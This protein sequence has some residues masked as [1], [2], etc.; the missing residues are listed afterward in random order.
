MDLRPLRFTEKGFE[1]R[2]VAIRYGYDKMERFL[3]ESHDM[4]NRPDIVIRNYRPGDLD[5]LALLVSRALDAGGGLHSVSA[6]DVIEGLGRPRHSP[7]E[8]LFVAERAGG[9]IGYVDVT[10][11]LDIGRAVLSFLAHPEHRGEVVVMKLIKRAMI[12]ARELK[13]RRAHVNVPEGSESA[14]KRLANMGFRF[15]RRFLELRLDL[16]NGDVPN[17]DRISPR[18]R[19]LKRGEEGK[20]VHIQNRSFADTWG[21]NPNTLEEIVYRLGLPGCA[22]EDIIFASDGENVMGYCWTR[23]YAGRDKV[24]ADDKGRISMLG[25]DPDCR[26]KGVGREVLLAGL[27][28]LKSNGVGIVELTV[29]SENK[30]ACALYRSAGFRI[31]TTSLWYEKT[32]R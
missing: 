26:G 1:S 9:A 25:V 32:L 22:P 27:S 8:D 3:R 6:H 20:L 7:E 15:I 29:D 12:R 24:T 28:Y 31:K 18:C 4:S 19:H 13:A 23:I 30:A 21:F 10:A 14:L 5:S 16:S 11:E 2:G 17:M